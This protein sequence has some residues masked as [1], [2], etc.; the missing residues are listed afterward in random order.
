MSFFIPGP[1]TPKSPTY[2][3]KNQKIDLAMKFFEEVFAWGA[4]NKIEVDSGNH[5][6]MV[7]PSKDSIFCFLLEEGDFA[8]TEN[9]PSDTPYAVSVN[10]IKEAERAILR[11]AQKSK[12]RYRVKDGKNT[13]TVSLYDLFTFSFVLVQRPPCPTCNGKGQVVE[14]RSRDSGATDLKPCPDCKGQK[15]DLSA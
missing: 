14:S 6:A 8:K 7:A 5:I 1:V 13:L 15:V 12:E 9:T 10:N 11:W 4:G 2:G 3:V